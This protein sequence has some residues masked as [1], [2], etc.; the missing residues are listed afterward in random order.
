MIYPTQPW[1]RRSL[2]LAAGLAAAASLAAC[3]SN[4]AAKPG[5]GAATGTAKAVAD[6]PAP[7]GSAVIK[8]V[9]KLDGAAPA[10]EAWGGA[11]NAECKSLRGDTIQLVK[12]KDGKLEDV[13]V[14][15]KEGLPKG[16]Y[17]T[18][19]E[20]VSFDQKSC[21]FAP[22][23]FGIM[24]GQPFALGNNDK[25]MH[26]VKSPEFNQAF[27][28]GAKRVM[29]LN[30]AA[31]MAT[32]KCDVHPWMRAYA[33]VMEHPYFA[34]TKEDGAFE[35]KGL[36][37]GEY[38]VEAWHEKLGTQTLAKVKASAAAPGTAELTFKTK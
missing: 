32:I 6:T 2:V 27:P 35:I 17:P 1:L 18:P 9:I 36:V 4:K 13:F 23:V 34:V 14:Y 37:D 7:T 5:G 20:A 12:A 26:N 38:T 16:S 8:G 33:G 31:V 28:F 10:P 19:T 30:D 25:L 21:E 29:K 22:R 24:A 15:V 11:G 3:D